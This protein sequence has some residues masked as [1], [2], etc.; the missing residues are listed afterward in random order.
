MGVESS[1][2]LTEGSG[3][4]IATVELTDG[5]QVQE[6][7]LVDPSSGASSQE[8]LAK[9]TT[10]RKLCEICICLTAEV[11]LLSMILANKESVPDVEN[12]RNQLIG[13][14]DKDLG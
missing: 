11:R 5:R 2:E 10:L 14:V 8:I 1:V 6:V 9:D 7:V 13:D 4:Q 12:L 3:T